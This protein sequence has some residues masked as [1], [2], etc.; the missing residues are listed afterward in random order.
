[1]ICSFI[2]FIG[3]YLFYTGSEIA[4]ILLAVAAVVLAPVR[5]SAGRQTKAKRQGHYYYGVFDHDKHNDADKYDDDCDEEHDDHS[6]SEDSSGSDTGYG[7]GDSSG[8]DSGG[9]GG[10]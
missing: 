6:N 1:M 8:G 10:D 9:G 5:R 2:L 4:G 7:S 3:L